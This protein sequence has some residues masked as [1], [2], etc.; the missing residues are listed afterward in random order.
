M[1]DS[2]AELTGNQES[3]PLALRLAIF[4]PAP[5]AAELVSMD[6]ATWSPQR[7]FIFGAPATPLAP[8]WTCGPLRSQ[9]GKLDRTDP[10]GPGLEPFL[11]TLLSKRLSAIAAILKALPCE[12]RSARLLALHPGVS[13]EEH[14]DDFVGFS[15]GQ[16]RVHVPITTSHGAVLTITGRDYF[17][18][19]GELWYGDF[20]QRHSVRNDGDAVR[21][22]LVVDCMLN[23]KLFGL[24]PPSVRDTI[25]K[26]GYLFNRPRGQAAA[27]P[28]RQSFG[29]PRW[30]ADDILAND[31]WPGG[32]HAILDAAIETRE[33]RTI[34]TVEGCERYTLV[35]VGVGEFRFE[36]WTDE[37]TLVVTDTNIVSIRQRH[38]AAVRDLILPLAARTCA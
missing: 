15:Y 2:E 36:G 34:L 16:L 1:E 23:D 27:E 11:D 31:P 33:G 28:R 19:P 4:D 5:L 20:G 8:G 38:G 30:L 14:Q 9:G 26:Y 29:I 13:V 24:F 21:V 18:Q 6:T 35:P 32:D 22:H 7:P 3:L 17:W 10:G 37:R 25:A 12:L